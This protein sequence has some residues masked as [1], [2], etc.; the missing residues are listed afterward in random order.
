M[1]MKAFLGAQLVGEIDDNHFTLPPERY[2]KEDF[3]G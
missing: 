3:G 2:L 1:T